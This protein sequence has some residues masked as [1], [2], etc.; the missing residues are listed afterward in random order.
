MKHNRSSGSQIKRGMLVAL[1]F[2]VEIKGKS[3]DA[4]RSYEH[5][6]MDY[7]VLDIGYNGK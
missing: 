3:A 5:N 2:C 7:K 4:H 1:E 6:A